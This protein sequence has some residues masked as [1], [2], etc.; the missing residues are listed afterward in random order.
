MSL[1]EKEATITD[2]IIDLMIWASHHKARIKTLMKIMDVWMDGENIMIH[3]KDIR[4]KIVGKHT[5]DK[6]IKRLKNAKVI[7]QPL[8]VMSDQER[9]RAATGRGYWILNLRGDNPLKP[10]ILMFYNWLRRTLAQS[11]KRPTS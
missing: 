2:Q 11:I 1:L 6:Y 7:R 8:E 3:R 4:G 10:E 9:K 5:F